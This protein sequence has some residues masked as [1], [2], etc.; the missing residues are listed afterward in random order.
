VV[1]PWGTF[2]LCEDHADM[3]L[4]AYGTNGV[5]WDGKKVVYADDA[6][7]RRVQEIGVALKVAARFGDR[8]DA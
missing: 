6:Q 5:K 4:E 8:S 7:R 2:R 1:T 3:A